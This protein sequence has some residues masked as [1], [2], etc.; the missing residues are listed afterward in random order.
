MLID[1]STQFNSM[2][3]NFSWKFWFQ[4]AMKKIWDRKTYENVLFKLVTLT[5]KPGSVAGQINR[6]SWF[7]ERKKNPKKIE[8]VEE[9]T[10]KGVRK[11]R[12]NM[13]TN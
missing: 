1:P 3:G 8:N 9:K 4:L 12:E 7:R 11:N 10:M 13:D 5:V 6:F 2:I